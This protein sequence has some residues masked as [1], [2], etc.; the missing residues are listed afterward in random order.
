MEG[1]ITY[2][3]PALDE[4]TRALPIRVALTAPDA[5]LRSGLFGGIELLGGAAGERV[6]V[7]P[8]DAVATVDGQQVV[9]VPADEKDTFAPRA[10][11]VGRRAGGFLEIRSGLAEGEEVV[12][13]GAFTL[14]SALKSGEISH[15]H[16]H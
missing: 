14:K 15:G 4:K 8:T 12:L 7:V 1:T 13:S 2:L 6:L 16:S 11:A 5:R 3:A 10:V 9:F